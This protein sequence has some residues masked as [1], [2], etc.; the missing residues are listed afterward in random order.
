MKIFIVEDNPSIRSFL[1]QVIPTLSADY[2]I[3]GTSSNVEEAMLFLQNQTPDLLLLDVE[4][5]DGK[6]FDVLKRWNELND[7]EKFEG[8]VIFATAH[9]H[10]A[11]QAIKFSALDYLL[12]PIN[13]EELREALKKA[14]EDKATRDQFMQEKL[15]ILEQN[16]ENVDQ[17]KP[18]GKQRIILSDA[19]RIQMVSVDEIVR[20]EANGSYTT[21]FLTE[22]RNITISKSIKNIEAMLPDVIFYRIHRSHLINLTFFDFLD[23]KD[24][25]TVH[26][27]DG[28]ILPI[29]VRRKDTLL[30]KLRLI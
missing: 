23:R 8:S 22:S 29:A 18:S 25:G 6:G 1:V 21:F 20:C 24:G 26:L 3:I 30:E 17:E 12:K 13:V 4:L 27:K 19:E 10:Y 2:Q 28:S 9:N 14:A 5:P 11:L 15:Q 16:L 7:K